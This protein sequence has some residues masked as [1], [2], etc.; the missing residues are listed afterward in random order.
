MLKKN[1]GEAGLSCKSN[2]TFNSYKLRFFCQNGCDTVRLI[3]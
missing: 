2:V 3:D 1:T